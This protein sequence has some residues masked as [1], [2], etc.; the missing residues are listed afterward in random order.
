M[1]YYYIHC[2]VF[3]RWNGINSVLNSDNCGGLRDSVPFVQ[4]KK[5]EKQPW[6]SVI[7]IKV[8]GLLRVTL[9]HDC[10]SCFFKLSKW[11]HIAQRISYIKGTAEQI[12][13]APINDR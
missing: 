8:A 10:F 13:K 9:L 6:I 2:S 1:L 7:C 4:F 12:E 11:Y 5:H 3:I